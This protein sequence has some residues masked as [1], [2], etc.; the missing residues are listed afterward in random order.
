MGRDDTLL[1]CG[2]CQS[3]LA[4][5]D[6]YCSNECAREARQW[7]EEPPTRLCAGYGRAGGGSNPSPDALEL[8]SARDAIVAALIGRAGRS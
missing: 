3:G 8:P 1:P 5:P 4:R 6:G 7:D 2:W